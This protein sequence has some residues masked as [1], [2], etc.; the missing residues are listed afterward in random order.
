MPMSEQDGGRPWGGRSR[1]W[2]RSPLD[3]ASRPEK[4]GSQV[5]SVLIINPGAQS[6]SFLENPPQPFGA[7]YSPA[8]L[9]QGLGKAEFIKP[10]FSQAKPDLS[11]PGYKEVVLKDVASFVAGL[12]EKAQTAFHYS[13]AKAAEFARWEKK[14]DGEFLKQMAQEIKA[15]L[16]EVKAKATQKAVEVVNFLMDE[17]GG[18]IDVG[19]MAQDMEG[20]ART[21]S[22]A[23]DYAKKHPKQVAVRVGV[24]VAEALVLAFCTPLP[25]EPPPPTPVSET[26]PTSSLVTGPS[27]L[28]RETTIPATATP[29]GELGRLRSDSEKGLNA[30]AA[31]LPKIDRPYQGLELR[32]DS[33]DHQY[34]L[35]MAYAITDAPG[36][37]S[38]DDIGNGQLRLNIPEGS[39]IYFWSD[40]GAKRGQKLRAFPVSIDPKLGRV[41]GVIDDMWTNQLVLE[42]SGS[43]G[44]KTTAKVALAGNNAGQV[45]VDAAPTPTATAEPTKTQTP[46]PTA[47]ATEIPRM[48]EFQVDGPY[49]K[50]E[51][52]EPI[53]YAGVSIFLN[54]GGR[55][56]TGLSISAYVKYCVEENVRAGIRM[57]MVRLSFYSKD[58]TAP[59][60]DEFSKAA[61]YLTSKGI[62]MIVT[63]HN[64]Q[65]SQTNDNYYLPNETDKQLMV[66]LARN[67][68][69]KNNVI[70]GLWNEPANTNWNTWSTVIQEMYTRMSDQLAESRRKP[71]FMVPGINW[72]S[73]FRGSSIP[74]PIGQY[75]L[76]AH[77]YT[78]LSGEAGWTQMIGNVPIIV[79]EVGAV[80]PSNHLPTADDINVIQRTLQVQ[81]QNPG[82]VGVLIWRGEKGADGTMTRVGLSQRGQALLDFQ[83]TN[84][85]TDLLKK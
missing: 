7:K 8:T 59:E 67:L 2:N 39:N 6:I 26:L 54:D 65:R 13:I 21:V 45:T 14:E 52:G 34:I 9:F 47:T 27:I 24:P 73:D 85:P 29:I 74:I 84:P 43:S 83:R 12:P 82:K 38:A 50:T 61:D 72:A 76:D 42:V 22:G 31:T 3:K 28:S 79:S 1:E 56:S 19:Q 64:D 11:S 17:H 36:S 33:R 4:L 62:I 77:N 25:K 10:A 75:V 44:Q 23:L 51:T 57:N 30:Y 48:S 66:N 49:L 40:Y 15:A 55:R 81:G 18:A 60:F 71:I 58:I 32:L 16:P 69:T 68:K 63:P 46:E 80:N 41:T 35:D 78:H 20:A 53:N 37:I 5:F 70:F